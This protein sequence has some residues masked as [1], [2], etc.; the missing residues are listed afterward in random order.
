V[1]RLVFL[2]FQVGWYVFVPYMRWMIW[3][4]VRHLPSY[5]FGGTFSCSIVRGDVMA[6]V[7]VVLDSADVAVIVHALEHLLKRLDTKY[8]GMEPE[9]GH[10]IPGRFSPRCPD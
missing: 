6:S 5:P 7:N 4:K 9:S 2:F 1:T 3:Q 8:R 10:L